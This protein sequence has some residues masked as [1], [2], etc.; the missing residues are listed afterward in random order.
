M[1]S[2]ILRHKSPGRSSTKRQIFPNL[3]MNFLSLIVK[4]KLDMQKGIVSYLLYEASYSSELIIHIV[5]FQFAIDIT[6]S[7]KLTSFWKA[8]TMCLSPHQ[9]SPHLDADN[10]WTQI[11]PSLPY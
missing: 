2:L 1:V 4:A 5:K 7:I 10:E 8:A 11:E 3:D 9:S 6:E